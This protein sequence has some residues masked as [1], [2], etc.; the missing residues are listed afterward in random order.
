M[1][2]DG[3]D[4]GGL[5]DGGTGLMQVD[6]QHKW[7]CEVCGLT[8]EVEPVPQ[9]VPSTGFMGVK[10]PSEKQVKYLE[11]MIGY[12]EDNN[13]HRAPNWRRKFDRLQ[14]IEEA[15]ALITEVKETFDDLKDQE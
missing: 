1:G 15:S 12:L 11:M 10:P 6:H 2:H 7:K 13:H 5:A 8:R 9:I 3:L 4:T 14:S